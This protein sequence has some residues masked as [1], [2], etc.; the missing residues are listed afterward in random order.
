MPSR[1]QVRR[2]LADGLGH[3]DAVF[4]RPRENLPQED[5]E[6]LGSKVVRAWRGAPTRPHPHAP[7]HPP[8]AVAAGGMAAALVDRVRD[9]VGGQPADRRGTER[10]DT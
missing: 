5:R 8:A 7:R 4:A 10:D 1:S 9:T 3:E 6:R 2:L